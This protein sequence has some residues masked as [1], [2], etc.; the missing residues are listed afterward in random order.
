[1][2]EARCC[3]VSQRLHWNPCSCNAWSTMLPCLTETALESVFLQCL[4]KHD[5]ARD[6]MVSHRDCIGIQRM[7]HDAAMSH[8]DCIGIRV[9]AMH[10][11]GAM[12]HRDYIGIRVR[13]MHEA[14]WCHVSQRLHW[15]PC[16]CN[17]WS[18]MLPCLT[19]TALESVFLQR[20]KHDAAMSHRDCI[21][22]RVR[23]MHE[24]RWCHVSQRLHWNPCSCN[25]WST[26]L[27]C[28]MSH[29]DY[30]GIRVPAMHEARCHVS[31]TLE[32]VFNAWST[33]HV[34]QRLH[35]NPCSCN[36]WSTMLPCLTETALESVFVQCMKHDGAMS[37]RDY[38]GIRVPATHEARCCHVSQRLHWNPC[39]CMKHDGA[40]SHRDY[41]GIRVQSTMLPCLTE[42]CVRATHEARCCHV[43]QRLHWNPC[44]CN[45]WSTMLPCLTETTLESV[46]LQRML[47]WN[48]NACLT[49][50]ALE[51]VFLQR[52]KHDACLTE[53]AL[54]SVFVQCMKHDAMSHRDYIGIRVRATHEARCCH[55]SQRL[56]W[57]PCSCNAWSTMVPCLTE[58]TLES[59]FV[60]CMKHDAAMSH[61][62]CIGIRVPAT[63]ETRCCHVS[64]RLHWNPCSCNAW[65]TILSCFSGH[66]L[67]SVIN[68]ENS[69]KSFS[70]P[71]WN[72]KID[73]SLGIMSR[74]HIFHPFSA[75]WA[76]AN[77]CPRLFITEKIP[78]NTFSDTYESRTKNV[79]SIVFCIVP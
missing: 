59:V 74:I 25:A 41:I 10:E 66:G 20:M 48:A 63:H 45:A 2:H 15:N 29:R 44:S 33:M 7:K 77:S 43:S 11:A 69:G 16:S 26:M 53:T 27:P 73:K 47:H 22:I 24:A 31:Q 6:T 55:V 71:H 21:G 5:A 34:S 49:E 12:S 61:R 19:E 42:T 65:M 79:F 54:E 56:H 4:M 14:R 9:P 17:A 57:N 51:S 32:S 78:P 72:T 35:W 13:T 28:A 23:A 39:S 36:A 58:T 76:L 38:I 37:H 40:M 67:K 1:M 62:D 8:R 60:Q 18:T 70:F 52:M 64:Q 3:H 30:I 75:T 50:T 68:Q 46:F